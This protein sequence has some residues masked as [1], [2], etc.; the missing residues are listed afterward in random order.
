MHQQ[1]PK[2][3]AVSTPLLPDHILCQAV[4]ALTHFKGNVSRA[5][6]HLGIPRE[7]FRSRLKAASKRGMNVPEKNEAPVMFPK[8]EQPQ[9]AYPLP[10]EPKPTRIKLNVPDQEPIDRLKM[11]RLEESL[12]ERSKD[13][14]SMEQRA[15]IA[16]DR[17][18]AMMGLKSSIVPPPS[19][20]SR[21][22]A[23]HKTALTPILFTSDFQCGEVIKPEEI[24]GLNSYNMDVFHDR[25]RSLVDSVIDIADN[26]TGRAVF[27]GIYYLRGGDAISGGIH[28]ELKDTDDLTAVPA[29]RYLRQLER[30]GIKRLKDRFGK[31]RVISIG[32]NHGRTMG[33]WGLKSRSKGYTEHNFETLLAWW[34]ASTFEDDPDVE[35]ITPSSGE[36]FFEVAGWNFLLSHGD[37]MGSRGGAGFVGPAATI[38]RGHQKLLQNW[39]ASGRLVDYVLTGHL[40][41]SL[42]LQHGYSNGSLA[43]Y[44]EFARDIRAVP[45]A[46]KQ[47]LLFVNRKRGVSQAFEVQVSDRPVRRNVNAPV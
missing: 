8:E 43:G 6:A 15:L 14:R 19:W 39:A 36:A 27:D 33:P 44:G 46:A 13:L 41:T 7:T 3:Q 42:K 16:E 21:Q 20:P 40:H 10:P 2:V 11:R 18:A 32:G 1:R 5:A 23:E 35:F 38:A 34:L 30:E 24:D 31:V 29:I 22:K 26:H 25:Y 37:R 47:W 9:A 28:A 17:V 45:D 4:L 12:A